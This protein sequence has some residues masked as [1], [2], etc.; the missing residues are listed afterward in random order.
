MESNDNSVKDKFNSHLE[1]AFEKKERKKKWRHKNG[2]IRRLNNIWMKISR[3]LERRDEYEFPKLWKRPER[4]NESCRAITAN[5]LKL[6]EVEN[7]CVFTIEKVSVWCAKKKRKTA[8][9]VV[10]VRLLAGKVLTVVFT[11]AESC[12]SL[13]TIASCW[14]CYYYPL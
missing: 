6:R 11:K 12:S 13:V 4:I 14:R 2:D 1:W 5:D 9:G 8:L 7:S 10:K 3:L